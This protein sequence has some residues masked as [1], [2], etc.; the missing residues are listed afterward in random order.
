MSLCFS[1]LEGSVVG[2]EM[3]YATSAAVWAVRPHQ[4]CSICAHLGQLGEEAE[5]MQ[6]YLTTATYGNKISELVR[7]ADADITFNRI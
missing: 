2:A 6:V 7:W 3:L 4:Q 5:R 1:V